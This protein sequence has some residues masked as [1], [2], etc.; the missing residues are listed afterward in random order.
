MQSSRF[1]GLARLEPWHVNVLLL[2]RQDDNKS[3]LMKRVCQKGVK[4]IG[5]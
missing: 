4:Y 1:P 5:S 2:Y 3:F